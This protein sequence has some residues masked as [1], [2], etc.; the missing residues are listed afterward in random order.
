MHFGLLSGIRL[1]KVP[2]AYSQ[3]ES[4]Q[5]A[6]IDWISLFFHTWHVTLYIVLNYAIAPFLTL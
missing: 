1:I 2:Q 4:G 5:L 3:V 6:M